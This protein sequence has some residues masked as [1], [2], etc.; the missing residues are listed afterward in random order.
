[1]STT[2]IPGPVTEEPVLCEWINDDPAGDAYTAPK[3]CGWGGAIADAVDVTIDDSD[4]EW[5][6]PECGT[7]RWLPVRYLDGAL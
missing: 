2:T 6:C 3:W 5:V 1:M 7:V 4:V